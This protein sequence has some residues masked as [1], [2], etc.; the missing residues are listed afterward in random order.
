MSHLG[1]NGV[2]EQQ[3]L[4]RWQ[5]DHHPGREPIATHLDEFLPEHRQERIQSPW[6]GC[7]LGTGE[8]GT[9][10]RQRVARAGRWLTLDAEPS[11]RVFIAGTIRSVFL[12]PLPASLIP[13]PQLRVDSPLVALLQLDENV[14]D[15]L[16]TELPSDLLLRAD[17]DQ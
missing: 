10:S 13:R 16:L 4:D 2:A 12:F 14:L 6:R 9:A 5:A 3:E 7:R 15:A 1:S 11:G 17:R 8:A